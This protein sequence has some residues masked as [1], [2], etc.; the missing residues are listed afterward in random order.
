MIIQFY[1]Y[2]GAGNDFIMLDNREGLYSSL[3]KNEIALLCDRNFGIGADGLILLES[4]PFLKM[5]YFNSD[6]GLSSFCGNGGRCFAAFAKRLGLI[7]EKISFQAFDGEH[8][9]SFVNDEVKLSM[10]DVKTILK[11]EEGLWLH[12]GSPHYIIWVADVDAVDII[13]QSRKIRFNDEFKSEGTNV[14]FVQIE[15]SSIRMRTYERGVENE[16]LSCGTGVTAA[17]I[18]FA[19]QYNH[20]NGEIA[21]DVKTKGGALRVFFTKNESI[22]T[23][24]YL[25]GA[26]DFVFEG[27][28]KLKN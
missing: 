15:N 6:G 5:V 11:K 10:A 23:N 22:F 27:K 16:T 19:H 25:Q 24:V 4:I 8:H 1:K 28:I 12:T 21:V 14:N 3:S 13:S 18:A 7:E 17:A 26:A 9:V 20:Q 2:Q